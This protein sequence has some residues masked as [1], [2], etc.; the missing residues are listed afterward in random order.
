VY[1]Y[2]QAEFRIPAPDRGIRWRRH[3]VLP[4]EPDDGTRPGVLRQAEAVQ[5]RVEDEAARVVLVAMCRHRHPGA[6]ADCVRLHW[7][8]TE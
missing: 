6:H 4:A 2:L 5:A 1:L 8:L 3:S 7:I